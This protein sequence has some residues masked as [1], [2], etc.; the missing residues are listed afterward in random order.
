MVDNFV[1]NTISVSN[2]ANNLADRSKR[3]AGFKS[4]QL[5]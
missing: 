2:L 3:K 4:A 5:G 1:D